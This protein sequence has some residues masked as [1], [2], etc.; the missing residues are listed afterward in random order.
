M[1]NDEKKEIAFA[2][3]IQRIPMR[4]LKCRVQG[5]KLPDWDDRKHTIMRAVNGVVYIESE[6]IRHCGT[7]VTTFIDQFG[8]LAKQKKIH[9]YDPN[10]HYL[11]P[12][13]VRGP[14]L[15]KERKAKLRNEFLVR[16]NEWITEE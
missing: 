8:F 1:Y 12:A 7:S 13:E 3:W 5:H 9:Y 10:Y 15:T 4:A 16:N 6:C 14:G 11:M 2:E